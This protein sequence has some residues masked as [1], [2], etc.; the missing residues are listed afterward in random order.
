LAKNIITGFARMDGD[1]GGASSQ[2]AAG[3]G[4]VLDID[5]FAQGGAVRAI[6]RRFEIPI[7]TFVDVPGFMPGTK[8]EYGGLIKHG[9]KLLFAYT[10]ATVPKVTVITRKAYG[11]AY[12]VMSSKHLR[13]DVNYAWPTAEIAVM[14]AKG[15]VEIIFR[16]DMNNPE[17]IAAREAEYK[18]RFAN[19]VRGGAARLHRRRDHAAWDA[20]TPRASATVAERKAV[21]N[22]RRSTTISRSSGP[23]EVVPSVDQ[24]CSMASSTSG[25][26]TSP[27]DGQRGHPPVRLRRAEVREEE[28]HAG[29][30]PC[31]PPIS[32]YSQSPIQRPSPGSPRRPPACRRAPR[33]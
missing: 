1:T 31:R 2:P 19:P 32:R 10:E 8:Q 27:R 25:P 33:R 30:D 6:L 4:G 24:D 22:P 15:A 18:A 28:I 13:G 17:A 11:G 26:R 16:A 3:A 7:V 29:D 21:E 14:G 20:A 12:D 23:F 9:A 5:A